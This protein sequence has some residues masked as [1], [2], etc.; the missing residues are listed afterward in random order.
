MKEG[1]YGVRELFTHR[2]IVPEVPCTILKRHRDAT[3]ALTEEPVEL[4]ELKRRDN[5]RH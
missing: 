1:V 3:V 2:R 4:A 5:N